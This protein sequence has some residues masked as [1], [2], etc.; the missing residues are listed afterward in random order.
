MR[1]RVSLVEKFVP[2]NGT[3]GGVFV[4]RIKVFDVEAG[5][6]VRKICG[7]L[8]V[9]SPV[10]SSASGGNTPSGRKFK[11]EANIKLDGASE[12]L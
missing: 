8:D 9:F 2:R 3:P 7:A 11:A 1:L 12:A 4:I 5:I 10:A 6:C